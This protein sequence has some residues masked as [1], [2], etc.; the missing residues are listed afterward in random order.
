MD[1]LLPAL[2]GL[3]PT[4]LVGGAVR[5]LLRGVSSV[6]LDLAIEGDAISAARTLAE[7]LGGEAREHDRFRTATLRAGDLIADLATTRRERYEHPGALPVVEPASL[8]E[9]LARRDFT[10]NAIAVGLS[11][12]DLGGVH[13]PHGGSADL[14]A[15]VVRILHDRSFVDDPTRLLRAVRYEARLGARM[16]PGTEARAREA[17]EAGVF[18]TVSGARVRD[19][20]MDLLAE[21]EAP[22]ALG[23][24][25]ELGLDRAVNPALAADQE[26]AARAAA[27]SSETGADPALSALAALVSRSPAE[28]EP[29]LDGLGLGRSERERVIAAARQGPVLA[30]ALT[31]RLPSSALHALLRHEQPEAMAVALAYG[32]PAEPIRRFLAELRDVTLEVTGD[33]LLAAGVEPSPAL[34]LAL[35]ETLRRKLDGDVSGREQELALALELARREAGG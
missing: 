6:D 13:D 18:A 31:D 22:A 29:W 7:R 24:V 25:R 33:D 30:R 19:E 23:R 8:A 35:E 14:Q 1:R 34:G 28:L 11:G 3:P 2:E 20:L 21:E 16:D 17:A 27:G 12:A 9:D 15:G 5:D 32:A 4:Y 10:L 26:L